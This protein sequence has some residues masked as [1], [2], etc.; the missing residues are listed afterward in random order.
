MEFRLL[1]SFR[2]VF[3]GRRYLHRS[4]SQGDAV[5]VELFE[6]LV[7][8]G[9]SPKLLRAVGEGV[10][11]VNKENRRL[12]IK[13]RRGDGTFGEIVPGTH[14]DSIAGFIVKRGPIATIE[15]GVEVKILAKAM[16][17]QIDRVITVLGNQSAE[18][19]KGGGNPLCVGIVAINRASVATGYE[20]DRAFRTDG[21]S[22]R[23]PIQ[24]AD[25]A[26]R[27]LRAEAQQHFDEFLI[28]RFAAS[29]EEPYPFD[30]YDEDDTKQ[31]YGA[32][33]ARLSR[34]YEARF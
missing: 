21:R 15:I 9:R 31:E 23:H 22:N 24:E 6:D 25:E 30:W 33:L 2:S 26:E 5:A 27:R 16:I 14:P 29:N 10:A 19:R 32:I 8:L 4:S 17:K 3:D 11:G 28:L 12:G 18:F 1:R 20:G 13:A 7:A 34:E